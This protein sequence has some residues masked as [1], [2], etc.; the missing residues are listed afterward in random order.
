MSASNGRPLEPTG[1][2]SGAAA[3]ARRTMRE[4]WFAVRSNW[5]NTRLPANSL[6]PVAAP[7]VATVCAVAADGSARTARAAAR[8]MRRMSASTRQ[9][10]GSDVQ[11]SNVLVD[12]LGRGGADED[13]RHVRVVEGEGDRRGGRWYVELRTEGYVLSRGGGGGRVSG[14]AALGCDPPGRVF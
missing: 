2:R 3:P 8:Q 6:T 1:I 12:L 10:D 4:Y 9:R 13:T 7:G 5:L 11:R 14:I